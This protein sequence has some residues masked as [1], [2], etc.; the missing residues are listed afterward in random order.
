MVQRL[1][2]AKKQQR[3]SLKRSKRSLTFSS[4]KLKLEKT[5]PPIESLKEKSL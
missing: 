2:L 5:S 3:S 4:I 1:F